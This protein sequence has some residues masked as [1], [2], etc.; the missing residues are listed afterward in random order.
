MSGFVK[1]HA[2]YEQLYL[3]EDTDGSS[4]G[5]KGAVI[6]I[7]KDRL[8][9]VGA[10]PFEPFTAF[11]RATVAGE[12]FDLLQSSSLMYQQLTRQ[13]DN[14]QTLVDL[15]ERGGMPDGHPVMQLLGNMQSALMLTQQAA[16]TGILPT[17]EAIDRETKRT[18]GK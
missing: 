5:V 1:T 10:G 11:A 16:L 12:L 6:A 9:G 8:A 17:S 14:L 2:A 7:S 15:M 18:N 3:I 4:S 13:H